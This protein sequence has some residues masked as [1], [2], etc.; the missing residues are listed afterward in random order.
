VASLTVHLIGG[1]YDGIRVD[2]LGTPPRIDVGGLIYERIDDPD[3]GLD[4]LE[5]KSQHSYQWPRWAAAEEASY[6][7]MEW[8]EGEGL[9]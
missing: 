2:L 9:A 6:A 7:V 5:S 1:R 4:R 3:T 8:L